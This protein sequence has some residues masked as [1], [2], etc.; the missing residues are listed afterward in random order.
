MLQRIR[1]VGQ[2][3]ETAGEIGPS[4]SK[5]KTEDCISQ[6]QIAHQP[7]KEAGPVQKYPSTLDPVIYFLCCR[8]RYIYIFFRSFLP[9]PIIMNVGW[10]QEM[11]Q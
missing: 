11:Y 8:K 4:D 3:D 7:A 1:R 9:F 2:R 10:N 5:P 6:P